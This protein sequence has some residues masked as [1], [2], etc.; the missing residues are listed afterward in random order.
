MINTGR[1]DEAE[2][3]LDRLIRRYPDNFYY[4]VDKGLLYRERNQQDLE[5][6]HFEGLVREVGSDPGRVRM[7]T[8]YLLQVQLYE[9]AI[10]AYKESRRQ[11]ND[12]DAYCVQEG[13]VKPRKWASR[14]TADGQI[15]ECAS[16]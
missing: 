4:K 3:Y 9:Y 16:V 12:P 15:G 1:F 7:Y 11:L 14:R 6:A 5:Q 2:S 8:Q 10:E 13:I